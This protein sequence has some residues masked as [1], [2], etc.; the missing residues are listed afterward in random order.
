MRYFY[1]RLKFPDRAHA[2]LKK[3]LRYPDTYQICMDGLKMIRMRYLWTRI[4]FKS[5]STKLQIKKYPNMCGQGLVY[6][7]SIDEIICLCFPEPRIYANLHA[8]RTKTVALVAKDS[9]AYVLILGFK[10]KGAM[11]M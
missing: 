3:A 5:A 7:Y 1:G 11:K 2:P 8:Q 4:F 10:E 6:L 9:R